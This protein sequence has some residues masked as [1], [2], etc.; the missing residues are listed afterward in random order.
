MASIATLG[1]SARSSRADALPLSCDRMKA[2]VWG[3]SLATRAASA[4]V[5]I[6]DRR[7]QT[8]PVVAAAGFRRRCAVVECVHGG[9]EGTG[10]VRIEFGPYAGSFRPQST[11]QARRACE[12][13]T[14]RNKG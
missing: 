8:D 13:V 4:P 9:S 1:S 5:S 2:M 14:C 6:A 7:D 12:A 3:C 11:H 10:F